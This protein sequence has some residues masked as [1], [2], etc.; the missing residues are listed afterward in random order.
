MALSRFVVTALLVARGAAFIGRLAGMPAEP[1]PQPPER[2]QPQSSWFSSGVGGIGAASLLSDAGH[3]IPTALLPSL[4][5]STLGAPAA[6]LGVIEGVADGLAGIAR[7]AGG[8][9][10]DDPHRRRTVAVGGYTATA[11]FSA[12]IGAATAAWQVGL[13]R[14]GAWTARGLRVPARNALL[15]DLTGPGAYGRAYG[16]ERAMDNLGAVAGPLLALAL[17]AVVPVRTAIAVSVIPGLLAAAAIVFAIRR[18]PR[19]TTRERTPIRIRIRP[20]LAGPLRRLMAGIAVFEVGNIA[21]TL[22]I[23][24]ATELLTPTRGSTAATSMA[25]GLYTGYNLAAALASVPAGKLVDRLS[26]RGPVHVLLLGTG[27]FAVAYVLLAIGSKSWVVLTLPFL[28][29][30][31]AIGCVETAEHAA[32]ATHAPTHLRGSAFGLLAAI[33][34]LG[35]LTASAIAGLLWTL[36]SPTAAFGYAALAML[37]AI[38]L[39]GRP[40]GPPQTDTLGPS[41]ADTAS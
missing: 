27:L 33:Q 7:F 18:T 21:A 39:L 15:A 5:T 8:P 38:S 6:A 1:V 2:S 23:L 4:L 30:G 29:A 34:S 16:F 14:A 25:I 20:V 31:A 24:R 40:P 17:I 37:I 10:A 35:N 13:L 28:A 11:V 26:P 9:L 3:E 22:L 19:P 12:G 32:V 41:P 36:V